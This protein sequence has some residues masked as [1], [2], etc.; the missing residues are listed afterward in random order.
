MS[1]RY[2]RG[3]TTVELVTVCLVLLIV[4][5]LGFMGFKAVE[6]TGSIKN[7][8]TELVQVEGLMLGFYQSRGFYPQDQSLVS[9]LEPDLVVTSGPSSSPDEYSL[10]VLAEDSYDVI[11]IAVMDHSG[12]C[13]A[14]RI[15]PADSGIARRSSVFKPT[16]AQP[17]SG[18]SALSI[19]GAQW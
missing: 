18:F 13:V 16:V 8:Q 5:G 6:D 17:C 2:S 19:V 9:S 14:S 10:S 11:G 3:F 4:T 7:T 15:A 1:S 12:S